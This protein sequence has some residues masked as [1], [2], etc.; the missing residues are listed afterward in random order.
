GQ[1]VNPGDVLA[2]VHGGPGFGGNA[3]HIEM[4][5]ANPNNPYQLLAQAMGHVPANHANT[6]AG[7]AF[8]AFLTSILG[9]GGA[10][11]SLPGPVT[12]ANNPM[13]KAL[14]PKLAADKAAKAA[15][16]AAKKAGN[17]AAT[18]IIK[19]VT[20]IVNAAKAGVSAARSEKDKAKIVSAL[21]HEVKVIHDEMAKVG[22][23]IA[24]TKNPYEKKR[25]EA[26]LA[27][28]T[29]AYTR[30]S[31]A[32]RGAIKA[33]KDAVIAAANKKKVASIKAEASK[34]E[35]DFNDFSTKVS[36]IQKISQYKIPG[37][38]T[39]YIKEM[40]KMLGNEADDI[41]KEISHVKSQIAGASGQAKS[42]LQSLLQRLTSEQN[43]VY[44]SI[45][46][47]LQDAVS[48]M[49][50]AFDTASS[51]FANI[52]SSVVS[53]V[54]S[55][56]DNQTQYFIKQ[57]LGPKFFQNGMLTP[58]EQQL[59]QL[60]A[61]R[62]A[63][64]LSQELGNAQTQYLQDVSQGADFQTIQTDLQRIQAA[65]DA[66]KEEELQTQATIERTAADQAYAA[67]VE[68]YTQERTAQEHELQFETQ[69]LLTKINQ[70]TAS[71][72]DFNDI[73]RRYGLLV[74]DTNAQQ[75]QQ[76]QQLAAINA[77]LDQYGVHLTGFDQAVG[78]GMMT[79][80]Q[81][82]T[83]MSKFGITVDGSGNLVS[84]FGTTIDMGTVSL[85]G[86]TG[87]FVSGITSMGLLSQTIMAG[88]S[89]IAQLGTMFTNL[90]DLVKYGSFATQILYKQDYP[91]AS[92][93]FNALTTAS[94][95]LRDAFNAL[96]LWVNA[97]ANTNISTV[98]PPVGSSSGT[99]SGIAGLPI[100]GSVT[101]A[102]QTL[103][104]AGY[105]TQTAAYLAKGISIPLYGDGA[106]VTG[107]QLAMIGES[108]PEA[109]IPLDRLTGAGGGGN[110]EVH[111]HTNS[112]IGT[113]LE[114]AAR[115]LMPPIRAELQRL[116]RNNGVLGSV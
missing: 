108:G 47:N 8:T 25:L 22:A 96:I 79:V 61:Q 113:G 57:V 52:Y 62:Q 105:D 30:A 93:A 112:I 74:T 44:Q 23:D 114:Q 21:R 6:P 46:T 116:Q 97:H 103:V 77:I 89:N 82:N 53:E 32:L 111:I 35:A 78:T 39:D 92:S 115:E 109:V 15:D 2:T 14:D 65:K 80:D 36:E 5:F 73:L 18:A 63:A 75:S 13:A 87:S 99:D 51:N 33:Q 59:K 16:A 72:T 28:L 37:V 12:A 45:E 29:D 48:S 56:F 3:G 106:I 24:G 19:M 54:T 60:E 10:T 11:T 86:L 71:F 1:Q 90:G 26:E 81:L 31:G 69:Q 43:S 49:Q 98:G 100:G 66:I 76:N 101:T 68:F 7:K 55:A 88:Q 95:N 38:T 102:Y 67:A 9:G 42:K 4:G 91:R 104:A 40:A 50:S 27:S 34:Y 85:T 110:I 20:E 94:G 107:P 83:F 70:G 58:A 41:R 84:S 64:A 17:A